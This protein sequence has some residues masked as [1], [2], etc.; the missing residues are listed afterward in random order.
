MIGM[1]YEILNESGE[2]VNIILAD[3]TFV[4]ENYPGAYRLVVSGTYEVLNESGEVIN[5]I[6]CDEAFVA[7][8]FPGMYRLVEDNPAPAEIIPAPTPA[9]PTKEELLAQLQ[10]LQAQIE[11]LG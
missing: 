2:V 1:K 9:T 11:A 3:E 7:Q 8:H 4:N 10:T 6:N 5:T